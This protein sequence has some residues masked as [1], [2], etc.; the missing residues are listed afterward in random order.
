[1]K[2]VYI[3]I[4]YV[5]NNVDETVYIDSVWTSERKAEKRRDELNYEEKEWRDDRG[6]GMFYV[7]QHGVWK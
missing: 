6:Y 2:L 4:C 1:M 7:E 3:V 5:T